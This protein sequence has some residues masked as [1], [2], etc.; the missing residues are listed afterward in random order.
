[1]EKTPNT[2][3]ETT[4][5]EHLT[6]NTGLIM[7]DD[8]KYLLSESAYLNVA[9]EESLLEDRTVHNPDRVIRPEGDTT[10]FT[11]A[12]IQHLETLERDNAD[13][14][15][16]NFIIRQ[17][18]IRSQFMD[19]IREGYSTA[20]IDEAH[21]QI[22]AS[23][24][25]FSQMCKQ[26]IETSLSHDANLEKFFVTINMQDDR[27]GPKKFTKLVVTLYYNGEE[28]SEGVFIEKFPKING[29][30]ISVAE[31][32]HS[33]ERFDWLHRKNKDQPY[34]IGFEEFFHNHDRDN[35]ARIVDPIRT[36]TLMI[37]QG[38][39]PSHKDPGFR[40]RQLIKRFA[41]RNAETSFP[42]NKLLDLSYDFWSNNNVD[43]VVSK[44]TARD[45]LRKELMRGHNLKIAE[46]VER[47]TGKQI[48]VDVNLDTDE[49]LKRIHT[50]P[51]KDVVEAVKRM[52]NIRYE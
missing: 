51:H 9:Q 18:V 39:V 12:G 16:E 35:V 48:R 7:Q 24:E 40:L 33:E 46:Y 1:M 20:F 31:T 10:I 17:P 19:K 30:I 42:E 32:T 45:L 38:V 5:L 29:Q 27:W 3:R 21:I 49:Y 11:T 4:T 37:M 52:E 41:E 25:I 2:E 22:G 43:S 26:M 15:G 23:G 14:K 6:Y 13:L 50:S 36:A 34:F 8:G 47:S 44:D 28:V